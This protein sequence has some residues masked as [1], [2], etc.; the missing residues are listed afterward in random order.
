MWVQIVLPSTGLQIRLLMATN[1]DTKSEQE[2]SSAQVVASGV[3]DNGI[4]EMNAFKILSNLDPLTDYQVQVKTNSLL[5]CQEGWSSTIYAFT[6]SLDYSYNLNHS[7]SQTSSGQ[8]TFEIETD[9]DYS[10]EWSSSNG[11]SSND[12]SISNLSLGDYQLLVSIDS[13][14]V[15]DT[16]FT[17]L[18]STSNID[19]SLNGQIINQNAYNFV[20]K[21]PPS[22]FR[23]SNYIWSNGET[24]SLLS[25]IPTPPFL[26]KLLILIIAL[27][28][29]TLYTQTNNIS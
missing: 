6:T 23:F 21:L 20:M 15:F 3:F 24:D 25:S 18:V 1:L 29:D 10:F 12:A 11:F 8:I 2:W 22:N 9:N 16:T 17:I 5:G 19:L 28:S 27:F 13:E 14:I 7:C 4:A 26:L